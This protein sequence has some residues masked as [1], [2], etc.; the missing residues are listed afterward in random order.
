MVAGQTSLVSVFAAGQEPPPGNEYSAPSISADGRFVS[1]VTSHRDN[2]YFDIVH[3]G[4]YVRDRQTGQT[5]R[6]D[7]SSAG[8][9][10]NKGG[11]DASISRDGRFVTFLSLATNL[12]P[13]P[14][15]TE[16]AFVHEI[17]ASVVPTFDLRPT[18]LAF[19][20]VADGGASAAKKV[21]IVNTGPMTL[22]ISLISLEGSNPDQFSQTDDCPAQLGVGASCVVR[23]TFR[24]TGAGARSAILTLSPGGGAATKTVALSATGI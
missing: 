14:N 11:F 7:V 12:T 13:D 18:G 22:P 4:T 6:V 10:A 15:A 2:V 19:G 20:N 1:F 5:T 9:P 8:E 17:P 3:A 23:V 21:T 24:P 16:A